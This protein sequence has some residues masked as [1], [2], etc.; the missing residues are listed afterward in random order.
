MDT[1]YLIQHACM[2]VMFVLACVLAVTHFYVRRP[3]RLF[4][5]SRWMLLVALLLFVLH[6]ALQMHFGFRAEGADVGAV[7]NILFYAPISFLL[8]LS[9]LHF[10]RRDHSNANFW[11]V[12]IIGYCIIVAII[13]EGY[14]RHGSLHIGEELYVADVVYL[15]CAAYHILE[16]S[17][18]L[19]RIRRR[20][21]AETG[22]PIKEFEQCLH[23]GTTIMYLIAGLF[24]FTILYTKLMSLVAPLALL[25]IVYF[26]ICFVSLGFNVS[27]VADVI[28]E[29]EEEQSL[30]SVQSQPSSDSPQTSLDNDTLLDLSQALNRWVSEGGLRDSDASIVSLSRRLHVSRQQL[31]AYLDQQYGCT[32]RVWLSNLRLQEAQ[33]LLLEH[34]E[35]SNEVIAL[36][37]GLSSDSQLYRVF[38][39]ATGCSPKEWREK[40]CK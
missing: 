28:D 30:T 15:L 31:T 29:P 13:A 9:I 18:E 34:P 35:Y 2:I 14:W 17:K 10:V 32:F 24:N 39:S 36:E 3:Y 23:W 11:K 33:R 7:V 4:E 38:R 22:N 16:P 25:A 8:N 37:C 40:K 27:Q 26:V 1:L 19:S 6:Y 21:E 5:Q 12:S 20:V